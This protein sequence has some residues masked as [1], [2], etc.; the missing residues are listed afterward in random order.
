MHKAVVIHGYPFLKK[1]LKTFGFEH[2]LKN[3]STFNKNRLKFALLQKMKEEYISYWKIR[4][5]ESSK[6]SFYKQILS[7]YKMANYLT[8]IRQIKYKIGLTKL[9]VSAH[10]LKIETGR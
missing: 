4:S 10:D 6:L 5:H 2:V 7:D 8:T 9:R 3:Q 1:I